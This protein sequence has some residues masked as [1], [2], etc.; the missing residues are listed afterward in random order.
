[1]CVHCSY[2]E[3]SGIKCLYTMGK[4][5]DTHCP[6]CQHILVSSVY[7]HTYIVCAADDGRECSVPNFGP[8]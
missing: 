5:D 4:I 3:P 8:Q 2:G 6:L 1:M 7:T